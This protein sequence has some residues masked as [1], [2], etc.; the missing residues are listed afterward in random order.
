MQALSPV[1]HPPTHNSF[2]MS[3]LVNQQALT[4]SLAVMSMDHALV[5]SSPGLI[6]RGT[7]HSPACFSPSAQVLSALPAHL[8]FCGGSGWKSRGVQTY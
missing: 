3:Q 4:E 6:H 1:G 8:Q 2:W 5:R 7:S